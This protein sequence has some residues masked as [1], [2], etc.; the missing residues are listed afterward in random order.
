MADWY[1]IRIQIDGSPSPAVLQGLM[2]RMKAEDYDFPPSCLRYDDWFTYR[3]PI[4]GGA[5]IGPILTEA[6]LT[7]R[8]WLIYT[9]ADNC[10]DADMRDEYIVEFGPGVEPLARSERHRANMRRTNI[11]NN[12]QRY[13]DIT[14]GLG[15]SPIPV[16]RAVLPLLNIFIAGDFADFEAAVA[17]LAPQDDPVPTT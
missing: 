13:V 8:Y 6:G 14:R 12:A 16:R 10:S 17:E 5:F 4:G 9:D 11:R 1:A 7:G 15:A 2:D 3:S